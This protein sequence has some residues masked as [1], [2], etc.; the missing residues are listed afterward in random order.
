MFIIA[1]IVYSDYKTTQG[2]Y[3]S[4]ALSNTWQE[5]VPASRTERG[6]Y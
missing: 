3:G 4:V 1:Y 5:N 2:A 6:E